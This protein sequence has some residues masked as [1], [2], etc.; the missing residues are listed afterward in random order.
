MDPQAVLTLGQQAMFTLLA[1][2][3]PVLGAVLVVGLVVSLF[4]ALT[5]INEATL[6]FVPKL[7]A[8]V[9]VLV[10]V[11]PWMLTTLVEYLRRVLLALPS[12]AV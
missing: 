7:L 5:Q 1:V 3:A 10:V 11:G 6:S 12:Y 2:A 9:A 4:Q 8:A